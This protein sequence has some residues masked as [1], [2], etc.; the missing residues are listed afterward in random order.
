MDV[1][2]IATWSRAT[3]LGLGRT[4]RG[5]AVRPRKY[6]EAV[7]FAHICRGRVPLRNDD[8]KIL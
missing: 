3:V 5:M 6:H 4:R 2:N 1:P 7:T 8:K